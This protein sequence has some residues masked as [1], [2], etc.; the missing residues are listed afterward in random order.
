MARRPQFEI[1]Y[2]PLVRDHLATIERKYYGIIS[3]SI[4]A[5]LTHTPLAETRNRKPLPREVDFGAKWELRFG[6]TIAL[7]P[8]TL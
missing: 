3:E 8:S 5:Q 4:A 1:V 6:R 7:E 2:G